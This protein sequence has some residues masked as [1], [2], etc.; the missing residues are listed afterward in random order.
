MYVSVNKYKYFNVKCAV[1]II[2]YLIT[3][4]TYFG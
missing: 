2:E 3:L 4:E 1:C